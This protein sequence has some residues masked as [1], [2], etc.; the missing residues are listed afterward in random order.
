MYD[1]S[2]CDREQVGGARS[3][4][5]LFDSVLTEKSLPNPRGSH[6]GSA[7]TQKIRRYC[8]AS[9]T[10]AVAHFYVLCFSKLELGR[11]LDAVLA[12]L[13][14]VLE[15]SRHLGTSRQGDGLHTSHDDQQICYSRKEC[16]HG[17]SMPCSVAFGSHSSICHW[18]SRFS[19]LLF[20]PL[21]WNHSFSKPFP[22]STPSHLQPGLIPYLFGGAAP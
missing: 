15:I 2:L 12:H 1:K 13:I 5:V 9:Q 21:A 16:G 17:R 3:G 8:P 7:L 18:Y 10:A 14:L 11:L 4:L 22:L 20:R 19:V 6:L